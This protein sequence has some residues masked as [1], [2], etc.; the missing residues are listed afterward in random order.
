MRL[1]DLVGAYCPE[2]GV[3]KIN[4]LSLPLFPANKVEPITKETGTRY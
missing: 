3:I 4:A 2:Q 1:L